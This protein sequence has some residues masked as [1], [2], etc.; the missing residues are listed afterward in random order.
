MPYPGP[1]F[2]YN[3]MVV[4]PNCKINIGLRILRKRSDGYH[5]IETVMV[6]V[7]WC[8]ILE[9]IVADRPSFHLSGNSLGDIPPE[10]NLVLKA[11]RN[12]ET[13][14]GIT[15]PPLA[16]Y[17]H[18]AI[19][20]GAGLGGG[21]ADASFALRAVNELLGLGF[22]DSRLAE[23]AAKTGADCPFFIYN[24][25]MLAQG[26]G[27]RLSPVEIPSLNG[28]WITIVKPSA[29]AVATPAAYA[30]VTPRELPESICLS[31][32]IS[33]PIQQWQTDRVLVN[34]F[35]P[36]V[37]ALRPVIAD[38]LARL[39]TF[40]PA[41]SAMSGSGASLFGIFDTEA[42]ATRAAASFPDCTTFTGALNI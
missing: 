41:Y 22:S 2:F 28:S 21:S 38:T 3:Y 40:K 18:K 36:S 8:D 4:F 7:P 13:E 10:K 27:Q 30:G 23:I 26:I 6:P 39:R 34:D 42:A 15:L 37:F 16:V 1:R 31:E 5:D 32:Y 17:L 9:I 12:L 20:D 24:R 33:R 29:E 14:T 25:P 35:E 19:P 11:L